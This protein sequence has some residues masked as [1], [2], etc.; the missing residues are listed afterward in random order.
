M[1][2]GTPAALATWEDVA[3]RWR[4][5]STAEQTLATTRI[6]DASALLRTRIGDIDARIA[7]DSTGNLAATVRSKVVDVVVRFLQNPN[8]A[9]Q[10]QETI[11]P[12]SYGMTF[13][14]RATGIFF[15]DEELASLRPSAAVDRSSTA[16]GTTFAAIRPGWAPTAPPGS[17]GWPSC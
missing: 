10:L 15:T 7:A 9:K 12:R 13:E 4:P 11:G 3:D 8:G 6:A 2:E 5:L 14:G 1:T 16:L 17:P